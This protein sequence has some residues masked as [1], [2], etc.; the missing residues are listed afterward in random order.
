MLP[1]RVSLRFLCGAAAIGLALVACRA[2]FAQT[3]NHAAD[4]IDEIW[5]HAN[6]KYDKARSGLVQSVDRQAHSGPFRPDWASLQKYRTPAWYEDAKFGVFI[7]WGLYSVPA[8]A[9]E[10]YSRNMY[11]RGSREFDHHV[12]TYGPHTKFGYKDFIPMFKAEQF[13]AHAWARLFREAGARYVVPV[14]EHHDGFPI[15]DSN[16]TDWCAGK[17]GPKRDLLRELSQA[18]RDEG[19]RFGTSTHRAEHDWF[20]DGGRAFDSDVADPRFSAFYGPAHPRSVRDGF[21]HNLIEDWMYVLLV[22]LDDW[23]VRIVEIVEKY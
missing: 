9:N 1:P 20:F 21:D 22:F 15:Y 6:C 13:D 23:L 10:W 2:A 11:Q 14:A 18:I 12:A 4:A 17:M 16:L 8:F 5:R 3:N 19:L 7:H